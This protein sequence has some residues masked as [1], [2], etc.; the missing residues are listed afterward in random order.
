M[1]E[2]LQRGGLFFHSTQILNRIRE[3]R[4]PLRVAA[5]QHLIVDLFRRKPQV[6]ALP[7]DFQYGD[8]MM[9]EPN[10]ND[11][12]LNLES[13]AS[14][15]LER[16]PVCEPESGNVLT[17]YD[18]ITQGPQTSRQCE[19]LKRELLLNNFDAVE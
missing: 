7:E 3:I 15:E 19:P 11:K 6:S 14:D 5:K 4:D 16:K 8:S 17:D 13:F 18:C 10:E 2:V 12:S 9:V 1:T